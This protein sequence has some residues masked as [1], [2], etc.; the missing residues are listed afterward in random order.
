M[1]TNTTFK[2]IGSFSKKHSRRTSIASSRRTHTAMQMQHMVES[3]TKLDLQPKSLSDGGKLDPITYTN[4]H[5]QKTRFTKGE[6]FSENIN[7]AIEP[8]LT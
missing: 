6:N 3:L 8:F 1:T 5:V 2:R 4:F 7:G